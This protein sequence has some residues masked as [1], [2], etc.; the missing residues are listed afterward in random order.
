MKCAYFYTSGFLYLCAVVLFVFALIATLETTGLFLTEGFGTWLAS[1][2]IALT[3]AI[4]G[5]G[6]PWLDAQVKTHRGQTA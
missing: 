4:A 2:L 5:L 6:G 1:A 3:L